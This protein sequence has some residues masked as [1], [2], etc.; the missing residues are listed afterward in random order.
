[1]AEQY[2]VITA[3]T[4]GQNGFLN[5][6]NEDYYEIKITDNQPEVTVSCK[7][8]PAKMC[9]VVVNADGY[10]CLRVYAKKGNID[11]SGSNMTLYLKSFGRKKKQKD[12]SLQ[13]YKETAFKGQGNGAETFRSVIKMGDL[14][15]NDLVI[16]QRYRAVLILKAKKDYYLEYSIS[17]KVSEFELTFCANMD[18]YQYD[19]ISDQV[20]DGKYHDE[21]SDNKK[22]TTVGEPKTT[23]GNGIIT[24]NMNL[25]MLSDLEKSVSA[26]KQKPGR[27]CIV[28]WTHS[29]ES[30]EEFV[31]DSKITF[32]IMYMDQ[33]FGKWLYELLRDILDKINDLTKEQK[34][35]KALATNMLETAGGAYGGNAAIGFAGLAAG[36]PISAAVGTL[37]G[38]I[39]SAVFVVGHYLEDTES[40]LEKLCGNMMEH[41]HSGYK[42]MY[43]PI[44]MAGSREYNGTWDTKGRDVIDFSRW[45]GTVVGALG[46]EYRCGTF[47]YVIYTKSILDNVQAECIERIEQLFS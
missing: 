32:Y 9:H 27:N 36:E 7:V 35:R 21:E 47:T 1:M 17:P 8:N 31:S 44:R 18:Q 12:V 15:T 45:D 11:F 14:E 6:T 29:N 4:S 2:A 19:S 40:F 5:N 3:V 43:T 26:Y 13:P 37:V 38:L 16:H 34:K 23:V 41:Y 28:T 10:Y 39:L 24:K 33:T 25:K 30:L 20:K 42:G 22:E 46:Q